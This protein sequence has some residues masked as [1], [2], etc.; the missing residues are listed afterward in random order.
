VKILVD[1]AKCTGIGMCE[2]LMP[3][4][5]EVQDDG[6]LLLLMDEVD[7]D[8]LIELHEAISGCPTMAISV[9]P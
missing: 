7:G 6:S 4:V 9:H 1:K 8:R 3:D 5:F 2:S